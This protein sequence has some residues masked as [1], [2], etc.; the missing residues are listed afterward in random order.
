MSKYVKSRTP[1]Q[2]RSHHQK[3]LVKCGSIGGI[4]TNF[5]SLVYESNLKKYNDLKKCSEEIEEPK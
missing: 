4:L 5:R 2:C 3:M 1:S